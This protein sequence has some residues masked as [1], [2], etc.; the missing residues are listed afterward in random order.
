MVFI[1]G[2]RSITGCSLLLRHAKAKGRSAE[3]QEEILGRSIKTY[4]LEK[5][6]QAL[7]LE[8]LDAIC[9]IAGTIPGQ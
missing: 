5:K 4:I 3:H 1:T 7:A 6:K 8:L 2:R 9:R